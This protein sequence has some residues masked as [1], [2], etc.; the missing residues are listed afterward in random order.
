MN[1]AAEK[2]TEN[3]ASDIL[4]STRRLGGLQAIAVPYFPA[5]SMLITPLSNLSIYFQ[6]SGHRRK[7]ADEPEFDRVVNYESE[8]IDFVIE[9]L[10]AIVLIDNIERVEA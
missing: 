9:E 8:N 10:E 4:Q 2:A 6:K 7:L 3:V 1:A 5:G